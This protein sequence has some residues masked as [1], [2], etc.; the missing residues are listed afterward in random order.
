METVKKSALNYRELQNEDPRID[1]PQIKVVYPSQPK[2]LEETPAQPV[3]STVTPPPP[4]AQAEIPAAKTTNDQEQNAPA[5][6]GW[7]DAIKQN[8]GVFALI[9]LALLGIGF[10]IGKNKAS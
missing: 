10:L 5:K 4:A 6:T 2:T 3:A 7:L 8:A 9:G 1:S